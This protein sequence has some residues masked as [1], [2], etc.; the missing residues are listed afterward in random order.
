MPTLRAK[1]VLRAGLLAEVFGVAGTAQ[2]QIVA[3][4]RL[5]AQRLPSVIRALGH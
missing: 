4:A 2:A 5:A 3:H 1:L